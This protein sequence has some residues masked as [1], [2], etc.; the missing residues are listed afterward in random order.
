MNC[1]S[2]LNEAPP[3]T[4]VHC[5]L[6][7][8]II[9]FVFILTFKSE[10]LIISIRLVQIFHFAVCAAYKC[11]VC[12]VG[13]KMGSLSAICVL[14]NQCWTQSCHR[15]KSSS[16]LQGANCVARKITRTGSKLA[17]SN[18]S[19]I[20][21]CFESYK[22]V[23]IK[24]RLNC[25]SISNLYTYIIVVSIKQNIKE[26]AFAYTRNICYWILFCTPRILCSLILCTLRL[27]H[28]GEA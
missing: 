14:I 9:T 8:I 7:F 4:S 21:L 6:K 2:F 23:R 27:T 18:G 16:F 5:T 17:V 1:A 11:A 26:P 24:H 25:T 12:I 13:G 10:D 28:L 22:N 19:W 20:S 3:I 15:K